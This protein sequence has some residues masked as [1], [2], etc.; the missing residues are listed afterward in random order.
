MPSHAAN[1]I[2]LFA[3]RRCTF[4][5][6]AFFCRFYRVDFLDLN[7]SRMTMKTKIAVFAGLAIAASLCNAQRIE[8]TVPSTKPLNGHLILVIAKSEKP[9][10]RMQ[11]DETY[12]SAQGFG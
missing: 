8:V 11:L 6:R 7:E 10:P 3:W 5:V 2:A 12:N 4:A 1:R 9:E